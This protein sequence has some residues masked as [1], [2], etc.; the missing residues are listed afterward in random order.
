[1][2][3]ENVKKFLRRGVEELEISTAGL[4]IEEARR[5]FQLTE[6]VKLAS[7]E[8]PLGPSPQAKEVVKEMAERMNLYPE[9][10]AMGLRGPGPA[11]EWIQ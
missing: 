11:R 3:Q 6:F 8:N 2:N 10:G 9:P 7:N 1:M 4:S 5:R